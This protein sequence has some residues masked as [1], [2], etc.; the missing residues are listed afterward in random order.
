MLDVVAAVV[1]GATFDVGAGA[2]CAPAVGVA[3]VAVPG[4]GLVPDPALAALPEALPG[5]LWPDVVLAGSEVLVG[6]ACAPV[7]D[8]AGEVTDDGCAPFSE[9][10]LGA[11]PGVAWL[12]EPAAML[13]VPA[14]VPGSPVDCPATCPFADW[15]PEVWACGEA[16]LPVDSAGL[17]GSGV[18][19]WT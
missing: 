1:C 15:P 12:V 17:P 7:G 14:V 10:V 19:A 5:V 11:V 3:V 18:I 13:G 2:A 9:P 4:C 8:P 6:A 16:L